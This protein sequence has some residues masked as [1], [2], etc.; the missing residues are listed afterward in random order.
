MYLIISTS[1]NPNS[2]SRILAQRA[3]TVFNEKEVG[4]EFF[5]LRDIDLPFCDGDKCYDDPTVKK[6][7]KIITQADAIIVA[8]PIYNYDVNA[9][10][11]N[12]LEV[13]GS[14][15]NEKVVGFIC[16]AGGKGSYMSVMPFAHSLMLDY[17]C[18]IIP[19]YVYTPSE[20]F[21]EGQLADNE[22][23]DRINQLVDT[24]IT[25]SSS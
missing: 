8:C 13:T 7:K 4:A 1:L 11:K 6:L 24:I 17:R 3:L 12:L 5:D 19:R 25:W 2:R 15:W 23:I 16:S 18:R 22:I 14:S 21:N 20:S 10:A 9:V